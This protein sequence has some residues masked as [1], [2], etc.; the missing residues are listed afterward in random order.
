M[1]FCYYICIEKRRRS[2]NINCKNN[3]KIGSKGVEFTFTN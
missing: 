1:M 2:L 3:K